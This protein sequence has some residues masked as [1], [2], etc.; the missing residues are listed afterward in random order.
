MSSVSEMYASESAPSLQ[1][2][3]Q[4][5]QHPQFHNH[6]MQVK[7]KVVQCQ[8]SQ[9]NSVI[10]TK[11]REL[12]SCEFP[13][14]YTAFDCYRCILPAGVNVTHCDVISADFVD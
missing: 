4:A 12:K 5:Y 2:H 14:A 3:R 11:H 9:Y 1:H 6:S 10:I 13:V 7:Y 8:L